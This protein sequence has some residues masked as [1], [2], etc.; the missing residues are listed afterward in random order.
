MHGDV[1]FPINK[2]KSY[3]GIQRIFLNFTKKI[4]L[5]SVE[6]VGV[7]FACTS[8]AG[9]KTKSKVVINTRVVRK[10]TTIAL[11]GKHNLYN[12]TF[13]RFFRTSR[14]L[15]SSDYL[16]TIRLG[17]F[18]W[19]RPA[20]AL[21]FIVLCENKRIFHAETL[22]LKHSTISLGRLMRFVHSCARESA[23]AQE[24]CI[25]FPLIYFRYINRSTASSYS[26][27]FCRITRTATLLKLG[28]IA[29]KYPRSL[30]FRLICTTLWLFYCLF[31]RDNVD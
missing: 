12:S 28:A 8:Q 16:K 13:R 24:P 21:F 3:G 31:T 7:N 29:P 20:V 18:L 14:S 1:P 19:R 10:C 6:K 11:K 4:Y 5:R 27:S 30:L 9:N 17:Q 25:Y 15:T 23:L 26:A 22:P 2:Q